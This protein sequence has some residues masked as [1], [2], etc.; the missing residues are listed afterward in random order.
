MKKLLNIE[1]CAE[2]LG[3]KKGTL[4]HW[5]SDRKIRV[6]KVGNKNKFRQE[7]IEKFICKNALE[8]DE[9]WEV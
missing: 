4:Y 7:D 3:I 1:E 8:P 9:I 2:I 6:I 5:V